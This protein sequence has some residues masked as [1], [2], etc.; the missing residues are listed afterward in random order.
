MIRSAYI[1]NIQN[2]SLRKLLMKIETYDKFKF[3]GE[4]ISNLI[5]T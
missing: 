2:F 3:N 1:N 5:I 4:Y